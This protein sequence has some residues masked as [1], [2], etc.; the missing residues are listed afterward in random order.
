MQ[1]L[2]LEL[3]DGGRKALPKLREWV[4][5]D[6]GGSRR[7]DAICRDR[8]QDGPVWFCY[9]WRQVSWDLGWLEK[10]ILWD[11]EKILLIVRPEALEYDKQLEEALRGVAWC[12][13]GDV[14]APPEIISDGVRGLARSFFD[15]WVRHF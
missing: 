4:L 2:L 12:Q 10:A 13:V 1:M 14:I 15:G 11:D 9:G 6:P 3:E 5:E 8:V 7:W